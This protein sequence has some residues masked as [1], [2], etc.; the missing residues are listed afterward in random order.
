MLVRS[1]VLSVRLIHVLL[2]CCPCVGMGLYL[3]VGLGVG[4]GL[5]LY[6][7]VGLGLGLCDLDLCLHV[8][9]LL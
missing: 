3:C 1:K 4:L 7:C 9:E 6:L 2:G 5:C 8:L